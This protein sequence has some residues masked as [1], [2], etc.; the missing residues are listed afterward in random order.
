MLEKAIEFCFKIWFN[1]W[2]QINISHDKIG[3][4][5]IKKVGVKFY[6]NVFELNGLMFAVNHPWKFINF[7]LSFKMATLEGNLQLPAAVTSFKI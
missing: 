2:L 4:K 6:Y 1:F 7:F 3:L 5:S